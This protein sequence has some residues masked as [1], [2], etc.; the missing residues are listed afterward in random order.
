MTILPATRRPQ[1]S[2][3]RLS[4]LWKLYLVDPEYG[5]LDYDGYHR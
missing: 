2:T 3:R 4:A 5:S 1:I